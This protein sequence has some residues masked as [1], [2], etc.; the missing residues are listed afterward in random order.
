MEERND[1]ATMLQLI[2]QPAFWAVDGIIHRVNDH[3]AGYFLQVGAP[4]APMIQSGAEE[5]EEF[6]G[7]RLYLTL[8]IAGQSIG[9]SVSRMDAGD[10]FTLETAA[11]PQLQAL[12]LAAMELRNPLT[13]I[14]SLADQLLPNISQEN[15]LLQQQAAQMNR[16]LH[17]MLRIIGN[18]SDADQYSRSAP[19]STE[20]VEICSFLCEILEKATELAAQA[21]VRL[22]WE[23]PKEM[24]FTLASS[25]KLERAVY[26]L[27]SNA[28]K[29]TSAGS[30]VHAKLI[31]KDKRLIFSVANLCDGSSLPG[32]LFNRFLR[33]PCLE[34]PRNGIGLGMFLVRSVAALHGGAVLVDQTEGG[35]RVTMT[36]QIRQSQTAQVHSPLLHIDYAGERDHG[37]IELSDVLPASAFCVDKIN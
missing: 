8:N 1:I 27:L 7:G 16:R 12:A 20:H 3:A 22:T 26:N 24:I 34:D 17:Q 36:L 32:N 10:I 25:E 23:V 37:L 5:Y 11:A 2:P 28:L 6:A 29:Y 35:I 15:E 13:S 9:A 19:V 21:G 33:E 30:S 31:R 18:M 4:I 14:L